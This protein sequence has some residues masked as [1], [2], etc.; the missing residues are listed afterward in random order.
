MYVCTF[1]GFEYCIALW[2]HYTTKRSCS[3]KFTI[4]NSLETQLYFHPIIPNFA[5]FINF[6]VHTYVCMYLCSL[7]TYVRTSY[8]GH[9]Y[10]YIHTYMY[11]RYFHRKPAGRESVSQAV[12]QR[13]VGQSVSQSVSQSVGQSVGQ[14]V[15]ARKLAGF[16]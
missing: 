11:V 3:L 8:T 2:F 13:S 10:I 14:P 12:G 5:V 15:N 1:Q 4:L 6:H 16:L 9:T 7:H